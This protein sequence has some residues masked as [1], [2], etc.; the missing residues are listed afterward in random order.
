MITL[1]TENGEHFCY[2]LSFEESEDQKLLREALSSLAMKFPDSYWR[3][4]DES[5]EFPQEYFDALASNGWFK[6][7]VP[8]EFGGTGL[9]TR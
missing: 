5:G 8:E 2:L 3:V 6:L 1:L 9:G 7:N 4:H